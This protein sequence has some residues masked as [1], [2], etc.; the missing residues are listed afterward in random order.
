MC[1]LHF[2]SSSVVQCHN[3]CL[4]FIFYHYFFFFQ[5]K[6]FLRIC[7]LC[8][9]QKWPSPPVDWLRQSTFHTAGG[10]VELLDLNGGCSR[11]I[12]LPSP[13]FPCRAR[14]EQRY[15]L[16]LPTAEP[17]VTTGAVA[18]KLHRKCCTL[19]L[20]FGLLQRLSN[21]FVLMFICKFT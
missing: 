13:L 12:F 20:I 1:G 14:A 2:Y 17:T 3:V 8:T 4:H 9:P 10:A 6:L 5:T 19:L 18:I 16:L 15:Q 11:S 7:K 21:V